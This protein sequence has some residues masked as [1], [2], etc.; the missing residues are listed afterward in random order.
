MVGLDVND[1]EIE[2]PEERDVDGVSD[3]VLQPDPVVDCVTVALCEGVDETENDDDD[4]AALEAVVDTLG[5]VL[6][7]DV[8][9]TEPLGDVVE[10]AD[11]L[12]LFEMNGDS[13]GDAVVV[14][15]TD[16]IV[17]F[18]LVDAIVVVGDDDFDACADC[19]ADAH[20][21]L[22]AVVDTDGV[23]AVDGDDDSVGDV[24]RT[25]FVAVCDSEPV[26]DAVVEDVDVALNDVECVEDAHADGGTETDMVGECELVRDAIDTDGAAVVVAELDAETVDDVEAHAVTD[27]VL[28]AEGDALGVLV[29]ESDAETLIVVDIEWLTDAVKVGELDARVEAVV[30]A[31]VHTVTECDEERPPLAVRESEGV[32]DA[33][34]DEDRELFTEGVFDGVDE[35]ENVG[36][37]LP[38]G[39]PVD[40][41]DTPAVTDVAPLLVVEGVMDDDMVVDRVSELTADV[42]AHPLTF[43]DGVGARETDGVGEMSLEPD[44]DPENDTDVDVD[45]ET[46]GDDVVDADGET[47]ALPD[48]DG[49]SDAE[50]VDDMETETQKDTEW[51]RV[52]DTDAVVVRVGA[53]VEE[54]DIEVL[55]VEQPLAEP[56]LPVEKVLDV[57]GVEEIT[58]VAFT[59]GE[60]AGE[61]DIE[62]VI[63][64][65][66]DAVSSDDAVAD[67]L[68]DDVPDSAG[69]CE[70]EGDGEAEGESAMDGDSET[71]ADE[72]DDG[73]RESEGVP[74]LDLLLVGLPDAVMDMLLVAEKFVD[75]DVYREAVG[76]RVD[77]TEMDA[78]VDAVGLRVVDTDSVG[79]GV[80]APA[81]GLLDTLGDALLDGA[82][83]AELHTLAVDVT[84]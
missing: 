54:G 55:C 46:E 81:V 76:E 25:E 19:D 57:C 17:V 49:V 50:M 37:M 44:G 18:E 39:V 14:V 16:G 27:A 62:M 61:R 48:I 59:E 71:V 35:I 45:G 3:A 75:R 60:S 53:S 47:D 41:G 12:I 40:D 8:D 64:A 83:V 77:V 33:Q 30:D 78:V 10:D 34:K 42:V 5:E 84:L 63:D 15:V 79:E 6:T 51:D 74:V 9:D 56:L 68:V 52:A 1:D 38:D 20:P 43:D 29:A 31:V 13:E 7:D 73:E 21:E 22:L 69:D 58:A 11:E 28:D 67:T 2:F 23:V 66:T 36:D 24:D 4:V 32:I 70:F 72:D 65:V 26:T 80:P 82:T